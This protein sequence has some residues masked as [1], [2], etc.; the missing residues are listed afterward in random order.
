MKAVCVRFDARCL[1][2]SKGMALVSRNPAEPK[3]R[4]SAS[5]N[6]LSKRRLKTAM[7]R[8]LSGNACSHSEEV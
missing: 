8:A 3:L 6:A 5:G 1:D 4:V 2:G 7:L